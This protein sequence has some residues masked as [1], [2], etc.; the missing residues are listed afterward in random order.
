[1][2]STETTTGTDPTT[3]LHVEAWGDGTPVVL[4]HGSLATA[5]EEWEAQRPFA[6]AGFRLRAPDRRGYGRSPAADGEDFLRDAED[7][8]E[9]MG[10]A[11]HLVGHS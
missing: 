10:S 11:A 7:I 6:D 8:A 2:T 5:A 1:M 4:V 9:L 3:D